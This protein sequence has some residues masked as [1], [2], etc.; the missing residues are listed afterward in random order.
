MEPVPSFS[1]IMQEKR[2][3]TVPGTVFF[4]LTEHRVGWMD[5]N[6]VLSGTTIFWNHLV[7]MSSLKASDP[8]G[9]YHGD[10]FYTTVQGTVHR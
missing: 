6:E 2:S 7:T 4:V 10:L 9:P 8:N 5:E 1:V 3:G